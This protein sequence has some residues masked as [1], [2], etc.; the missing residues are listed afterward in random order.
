M[1]HV[2]VG[3]QT[4]KV[5]VMTTDALGYFKQDHYNTVGGNGGCRVGE[6]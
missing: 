3:I 6:V 1:A 5:L 2:H 4:L